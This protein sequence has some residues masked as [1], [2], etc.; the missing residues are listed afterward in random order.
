MFYVITPDWYDT[1]TQNPSS[2]KTRIYIFYIANIVAADV[3]GISSHDID[4]VKP[5]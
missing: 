1:G 2:S 3:L 5:R 4:L